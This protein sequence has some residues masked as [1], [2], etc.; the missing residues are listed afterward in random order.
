MYNKKGFLQLVVSLPLEGDQGLQE[1]AY[2]SNLLM[3]LLHLKL[4]FGGAGVFVLCICF[5]ILFAYNFPKNVI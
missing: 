3:L 5:L 1:R 4:Q 2:F